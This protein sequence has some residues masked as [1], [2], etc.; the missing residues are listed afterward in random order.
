MDLAI[1]ILCMMLLLGG[2][3]TFFRWWGL[4][5]WV[6]GKYGHNRFWEIMTRDLSAPPDVHSLRRGL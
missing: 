2:L 6:R 4:S 5:A 1:R 3:R